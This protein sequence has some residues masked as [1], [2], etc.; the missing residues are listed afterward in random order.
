MLSPNTLSEKV[1]R[2]MLLKDQCINISPS[3]SK[4]KESLKRKGKEIMYD[5]EFEDEILI[6]ALDLETFFFL[7]LTNF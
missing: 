7:P 3:K 5:N 1:K 4:A 2:L 6:M